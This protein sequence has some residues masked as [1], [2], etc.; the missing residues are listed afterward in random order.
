MTVFEKYFSQYMGRIEGFNTFHNEVI[1][2]PRDQFSNT[3]LDKIR[4]LAGYLLL[5]EGKLDN[6][7]VNYKTT[8]ECIATQLKNENYPLYRDIVLENRY[9]SYTNIDVHYEKIGRMFRHLMSLCAFFGFV[10]SIGKQQKI[11][12]YEKCKEYYLSDNN[13]LMPVA[14][15]NLMIL[16]AKDNDF[17]KSLRGI[18]IDAETD[19]RPAYAILRYMDQ[20]NR[21][22]TKFEVSI[23]LGRIDAVK[24]ETSI[25]ERAL[26][27]GSIL[28]RD[29]QTQ[30][31]YFFSNMGWKYSNGKLF[32]YASSQEPYF[33]FNSF[34][35]FLESF[36]LIVHDNINNTY[37]LT[38]YAKNL[39]ADDISY[40]IADL[41]RLLILIDDYAADNS[42]LNDLILYQRNPELLRL[43][44][45]DATF[46]EKMNK[47]S[48][49]N[50][51]YDR[52]GKKQR[53]R[54][55]AEL[56]KIQADYKC[57][58]AQRTIFKMPNGKYYCEAHHIIEFN[59]ENGPDITNN[60]V[61]LGPEAHMLI[62]HACKDEK[63]DV[64][65]QL[66]TNGAVDVNRF[67]EMAT[68]YNCLTAAHIE[69]LANKKAITSNEKAELLAIIS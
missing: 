50:P 11:Y 24:T 21:P 6:S 18:T 23:L 36:E 12:N 15:N 22:V 14:R 38:E 57:Q 3:G 19:Y 32:S 68:V 33:K 65:L 49:N 39:L 56:A 55:I 58:Y 67:K 7:G 48:L 47:R 13:I 62:H 52:S 42:E 69:A 27:I 61:I 17:I 4:M 43:A 30:I 66:R 37:T 45:E 46:I 5:T 63:D 20:I 34:M 29:E 1:N 53:N 16:N 10:N 31:P 2:M 9:F 40:L 28:P 8:L 41:E 60:L 44:R 51:I 26:K 64:F 59:T 35:L 25:I 54:L